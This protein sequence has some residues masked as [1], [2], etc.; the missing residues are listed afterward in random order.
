MARTI[1]PLLAILTLAASLEGQVPHLAGRVTVN[2]QEGIL[3]SSL[4]LTNF[5]PR[6]T[7]RF[8]LRAPLNIKSVTEGSGPA[9]DYD[10]DY[11]GRMVGEAREYVLR[12]PDSL[13]PFA[14]MWVEYRGAVPVFETNTAYADWKGRIAAT[15]GTLRAA[16]QSRWYP[17][18]FDSASGRM[19]EVVTYDISM[20]CRSCRS[21]YINGSA[22]IADTSGVF[23]STTPRTLLLYAGDFGFQSDSAMTLVGGT[24]SV[25]TV[26]TFNQAI[27]GIGDYYDKLLGVPYGERPVL[28]SFR[29]IYREHQLGTVN[30]QFVTWPTITFSGGL[31][32]DKLVEEH[33]GE[34]RLPDWLWGSLSHEMAHYYFGTL[35]HPVGP[36]SWF[37]LESTAEYLSLKSIARTRG[38]D[39]LA[40]RELAY[41]DALG[42][43]EFPA[44]GTITEADQISGM[45][46]Y[47]FAPLA[48]LSLDHR[49]GEAKVM[50]M[51][52]ALL[53]APATESADYAQLTRAAAIAG[54]APEELARPVTTATLRAEALALRGA[55][56]PV[57]EVVRAL[58]GKRVALLGEAPMHGFGKTLEFKADVARRLVN[59]CHYNALFIESGAYDFLKIQEELES[60]RTVTAPMI[61]AAIGGLWATREVEPLIPFLL[62]KVRSGSLVLGGLDD[63]LGRGTYAQR[64][65]PADLV[66]HLQG[67]DKVRCLA[68]LQKHTLWQYSTDA[69][70]GPTD[71][72]LMLGCLNTIAPALAESRAGTA[73]EYQSAMIENLKRMFARDFRSD[74]ASGADATTRDFNERDQSMYANFRWLMSRLPAGSKVIVW[75]ATVHAAKDLS[76]VPEREKYVPLGSYIRRDYKDQAFV[77][78]ISANSGTYAMGRQ[79]VQTFTA[80]PAN[81][82]EGHAFNGGGVDTRYLGA[83]ELRNLGPMLARPLGPDFKFAKWGNV[84]D[85]LVV[86][87]EERPPVVSTAPPA[88]EG[89]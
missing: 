21:L 16:E 15:N 33:A 87:R 43:T 40:A 24:A 2:P 70:Y 69:P 25:R 76:G 46:R 9:L 56:E 48:L 52:R 65:M 30:W 47:Y 8:L 38:N 7:M 18:L 59:E 62:E 79:P 60:G 86:I 19:E 26:A 83:S 44:L 36:L 3:E 78:G 20:Q 10:G 84:L 89:G 28:L 58:C 53:D 72:A 49:V 71:K 4:C 31:D 17:T 35:R 27:R 1:H 73:R 68:I 51:L 37:I 66:E 77:L 81:S 12:R 6:H 64:Q 54:I 88:T 74:V 85:G 29:S 34:Q 61:A 42:T 41:L 13:P 11:N 55:S 57:N 75:T 39:V 63:Q 23:A 80:A 22:P 50:R 5:A 45:H 82:L 14:S 32:F 67:E